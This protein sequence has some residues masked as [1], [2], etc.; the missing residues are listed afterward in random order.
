MV[1]KKTEP[2]KVEGWSTEN[3]R[4]EEKLCW[5]T[6]KTWYEG[7]VYSKKNSMKYGKS[8]CKRIEEATLEKSEVGKNKRGGHKGRGNMVE[9]DM[10]KDVKKYKRRMWSE[11]C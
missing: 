11:N 9:W 1:M 6:Q 8:I 4:R 10:V 5:R 2:K 7:E 3:I